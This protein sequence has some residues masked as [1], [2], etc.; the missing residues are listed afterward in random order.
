M[1]MQVT[2]FA[3]LIN[4]KIIVPSSA[5]SYYAVDKHFLTSCLSDYIGS[6]YLDPEWYL[7][8]Y[9]DVAQAIE[10]KAVADVQEHYCRYGFWE[11][12]MPYA[13]QVQEAWYLESYPD[14]AQAITRKAIQSGQE[15]YDRV[16]FQEGRFPHPNFELR[17]KSPS[18]APRLA[19]TPQAGR[20]AQPA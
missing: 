16:G 15:H 3:T 1:I 8:R 14:V 7:L 13:I 9:P 10:R 17:T 20:Q 6:I 2:T 12:R 4:S 19:E 5:T 18:S 11:N